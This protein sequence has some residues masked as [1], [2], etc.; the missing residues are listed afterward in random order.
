MYHPAPNDIF[1]G[2]E[3][4]V[5]APVQELL[6]N[7]V[8]DCR[9][10]PYLV[11]KR[12]PEHEKNMLVSATMRSCSSPS[13]RFFGHDL[14]L[15]CCKNGYLALPTPIRSVLC[16]VWVYPPPLNDIFSGSGVP[17]LAP[18]PEL[19]ENRVAACIKSPYLCSKRSPGHEKNIHVSATMRSFRSPSFRFFG[20]DLALSCC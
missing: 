11:S 7:R 18:I 2:S 6:E 16:G 20:R 5:L 8:E 4:P 12:S 13:F 14:T 9:K 15:K 17:A 3:V 19:L 1:S 10:S